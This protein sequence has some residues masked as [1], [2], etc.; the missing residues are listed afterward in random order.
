MP[1]L[2]N[3]NGNKLCSDR[4]ARHTSMRERLIVFHNALQ[5]T[6]QSGSTFMGGAIVTKVQCLAI[7]RILVQSIPR[8]ITHEKPNAV[9]QK[10]PSPLRNLGFVDSQYHFRDGV[11]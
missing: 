8:W 11:A 1:K 7:V 10:P 2:E 9:N 5:H 4:T 6:M 3:A